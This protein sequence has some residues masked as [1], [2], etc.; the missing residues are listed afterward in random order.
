MTE[1]RIKDVKKKPFLTRF[2]HYHTI[3]LDQH[4][5]KFNMCKQIKEGGTFETRSRLWDFPRTSDAVRQVGRYVGVTNAE[6]IQ[7]WVFLLDGRPKAITTR[8][9]ATRKLVAD[10]T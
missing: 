6:I 4:I 9:F 10:C 7:I 2:M 3:L 8:K 5:G 1:R